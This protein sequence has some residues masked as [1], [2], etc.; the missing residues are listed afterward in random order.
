[1]EHTMHGLVKKRSDIAGQHKI[2][3]QAADALKA[4]LNAI[5]RALVLVGYQDDPNTP[6]GVT[7][8]FVIA[9]R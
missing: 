6:S 9:I 2:A 1:M 8:L 7:Y 4:D 3:M 5:D